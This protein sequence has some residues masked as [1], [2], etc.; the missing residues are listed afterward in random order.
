M[1]NSLIDNCQP[2]L[3]H[4]S[5]TQPNSELS[6]PAIGNAMLPAV[7]FVGMHN[8]PGM[9]P[10]DTATQTGKLIDEIIKQLPFKCEKTN[11]CECDYLPQD[12][13][14]INEHYAKWNEKYHPENRDVVVLLGKWVESNFFLD[15]PKIIK[16]PHPASVMGNA[17][18]KEYVVKAV[19][20]II[21]AAS[22]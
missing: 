1:Q 5:D 20:E 16:L 2:E 4:S 17:G 10:L 6:P 14:E 9:K 15:Y 3:V 8:K 18:R 11:L 7:L 19:S 22:A 12:W 13:L 21:N